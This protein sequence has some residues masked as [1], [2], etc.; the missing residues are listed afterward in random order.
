MLSSGGGGVALTLRGA[1]TPRAG[2]LSVEGEL[3]LKDGAPAAAGP[4]DVRLNIQGV[5]VAAT[6]RLLAVADSM[7][8]FV[9]EPRLG[10]AVSA[11]M[12]EDAAYEEDEEDR[13]RVLQRVG[14]WVG[15]PGAV[16]SG[17]ACLGAASPVF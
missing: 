14:G 7:Q 16:C 5:Y 9:L 15:G 11:Q 3:V 13:Q 8:P 10:G 12:G 2:V 4:R 17:D 6:G 1:A